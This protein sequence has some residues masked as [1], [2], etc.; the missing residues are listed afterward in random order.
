MDTNI[1]IHCIE[2]SQPIGIF[3]I[4]AINSDDL[5]RISY[6]DV[7][8]VEDRDFERYLGIQ[9]PLSMDR[10]KE[11]K[12]YVTH[13]DATFPTSII[14]AITS[15][16]IISYDK[17]SGVMELK[18]DENVAKIIDGQ[19]RIAGLQGYSGVEP[20]DLNVTIFVDMDIENQAMV[21]GTIN[22]AQT[23]VNKSL[24]YDLFDL[25]NTRSPQKTCHNIAVF[26]NND[27]KSPFYKRIKLL[28]VASEK[29]QT[30]T[31]AAI[32]EGILK[33]ISGDYISAMHDRDMLLRNMKLENVI[34]ADEKSLFFR[35]FFINNDDDSIL[36]AIWN[37]FIAVKRKWPQAWNGVNIAG[38]ILPRT[39]GFRALI[40]FLKPV[41]LDLN[42]YKIIPS[43]EDY[44]IV[45]EKILIED[46][47]FQSNKYLPG[48]SGESALYKDLLRYYQTR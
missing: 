8:R 9:R 26:L 1:K 44:Q 43:I 13:K 41:F 22:L 46:T 7:R 47:D 3:Y 45:F 18:N 32:V 48:T 24:A 15:E 4:G 27:E 29:N 31:Q 17:K 16:N 21:F 39:N 2:L 23:K 6:A 38:N 11:I 5:L 10:V 30:L 36:K 33:Y 28:G 35:N 25:T 19:H 20:F 12:E 14:L 40:R 34:D 42:G 37:Y